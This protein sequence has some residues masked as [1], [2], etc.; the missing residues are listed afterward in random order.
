MKISAT[1]VG[2]GG[3]E[4][5]QEEFPRCRSC[6]P[7]PVRRAGAA[8]ELD[9]PATNPS[10]PPRGRRGGSDRFTAPR[11]S[12]AGTAASAPAGGRGWRARSQPWRPRKGME[13]GGG[14]ATRR[15]GWP[16]AS[17]PGRGGRR[18]TRARGGC[19]GWQPV[20]Y[21]AGHGRR[22]A[23]SAARVCTRSGPGWSRA[24]TST[25]HLTPTPPASPF[26]DCLFSSPFLLTLNTPFLLLVSI[27][28][29]PPPPARR[30]VSRLSLPSSW[31]ASAPWR[32][33]P[34]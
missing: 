29:T 6:S 4:S 2:W 28:S 11:P 33:P 23:A 21:C 25:P 27:S 14:V 1:F 17:S 22:R 9:R 26:I 16:G 19:V 20:R 7:I 12:G 13:R 30:F 24:S 10:P 15:A 34:S 18:K 5:L 3:R 8:F 31:P 32:P